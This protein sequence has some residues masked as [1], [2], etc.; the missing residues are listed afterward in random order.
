[1]SF[2]S[3]MIDNNA[4]SLCLITHYYRELILPFLRLILIKYLKIVWSDFYG[5]P[6]G[7]LYFI[8]QLVTYSLM[9]SLNQVAFLFF[10]TF[11]YNS[12]FLLIIWLFVWWGRFYIFCNSR[13][14]TY[15]L[16]LVLFIIMSFIELLIPTPGYSYY[17]TD[18]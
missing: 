15:H 1:M 18:W 8:K 16:L 3:H 14:K 9:P 6:S 5:I 17:I 11:T 12:T 4:C 7:C 13:K 2:N 10:K